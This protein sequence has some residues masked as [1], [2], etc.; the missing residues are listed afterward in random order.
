MTSPMTA[1]PK[2]RVSHEDRRKRR[3]EIAAFL[4]TLFETEPE[5]KT[6]TLIA[7]TARHFGV[8]LGSVQVARKEFAIKRSSKWQDQRSEK[9]K[10]LLR[11][12]EKSLTEIA[13][14]TGVSKQRVHQIY[15]LM[16]E[17]GEQVPSRERGMSQSRL[18]MRREQKLIERFKETKSVY[19]ARKFAQVPR[20]RAIALLREAGLVENRYVKP[21]GSPR[22]TRTMLILGA[23]FDDSVTY[24][25]IAKKFKLPPPCIYNIAQAAIYCGIPIPVRHDGT[26]SAFGAYLSALLLRKMAKNDKP[27]MLNEFSENAT[28]SLRSLPSSVDVPYTRLNPMIKTQVFRFI[29]DGLATSAYCRHLRARSFALTE[30]GRH[31]AE[32]LSDEVMSDLRQSLI[33]QISS[34]SSESSSE[35]SSAGSNHLISG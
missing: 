1:E 12:T 18:G 10:D 21:D 22:I 15:A 20:S 24:A 14:E 2:Q 3:E 28:A 35:S 23:M 32:L 9:I 6:S 16:I 13:D 27:I 8:C 25:D 11:T 4:K 26:V 31:D 5:Q 34:S 33:A 7:K 19:Q 17:K 30:K 29:R